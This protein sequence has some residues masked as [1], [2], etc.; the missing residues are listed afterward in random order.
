MSKYY[1]KVAKYYSAGVWTINQVRNA[2]VKGWITPNEFYQIT[3][4]YYG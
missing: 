3:G 4:M 1:N 2:V